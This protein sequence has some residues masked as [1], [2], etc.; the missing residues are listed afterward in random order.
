LFC[1]LVIATKSNGSALLAETM[2]P[3]PPNW[4]S[5]SGSTVEKLHSKRAQKLHEQFAN[6]AEFSSTSVKSHRHTLGAFGSIPELAR[7]DYRY[8]LS[9]FWGL[10]VGAS[11]PMPVQ[12]DIDMPSDVIKA[13]ASIGLAVAHPAFNIKFD[14]DWGPHVYA[15]AIWHPFG[16]TWYSSAAVGV[17]SIR[18]L[19][20]AASPLRICSLVEA[21]K[22]PPCGNDAAAIQTRNSISLTADIKLLSYTVRAATGWLLPLTPA[23]VLLA[24]AGLFAPLS[25]KENTKVLSE[26]VSPDGNSEDL[27]GALAELRSKSE[28]DLTAKAKSELTTYTKKTLPVLGVGLAYRF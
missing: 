24:E 3:L 13:D 26:L 23:W 20:H 28:V 2:A 22:E 5:G 15:G 9:P 10:T 8:S 21:A 16:G 19:G 14:I 7:L 12:I 27:F 4:T 6:E 25:T 17:R 18:I 1:V 11:A